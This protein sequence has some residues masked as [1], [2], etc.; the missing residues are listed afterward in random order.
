MDKLSFQL[1]VREILPG[2]FLTNEFNLY[3]YSEDG[4]RVSSPHYL[5]TLAGEVRV[6]DFWM[7]EGTML[8][9]SEECLSEV[10]E[11]INTV[12]SDFQLLNYPRRNYYG[13][14]ANNSRYIYLFGFE[15]ELQHLMKYHFHSHE[16]RRPTKEMAEAVQDLAMCQVPPYT[17]EDS[18]EIS[19]K[20]TIPG[21][22]KTFESSFV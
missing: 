15:P 9:L 17:K 4:T 8:K 19:T 16:Y 6:Y 12:L 3:A 20:I 5:F 10:R 21:T 14:P 1:N 22:L 7:P 11:K 2:V 13:E 18:L